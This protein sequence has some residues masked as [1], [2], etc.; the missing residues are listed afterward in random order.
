MNSKKRSRLDNSYPSS[1]SNVTVSHNNDT[2][3]EDQT[4]TTNTKKNIPTIEGISTTIA[5]LLIHCIKTQKKVFSYMATHDI[6]YS[7]YNSKYHNRIDSNSIKHYSTNDK[8]ITTTTNTIFDRIRQKQSD[9][10]YYGEGIFEKDN[11]QPFHTLSTC[12]QEALDQFLNQ[13]EKEVFSSS[14]V[15]YSHRRRSLIDSNVHSV[16]KA[17][18]SF[19]FDIITDTT[20]TDGGGEE[21]SSSSSSSTL[22]LPRSALHIL[23]NILLKYQ[24]SFHWLFTTSLEGYTFLKRF[25]H[26]IQSLTIRTMDSSASS[27]INHD[28]HHS[29]SKEKD[30]YHSLQYT[31]QIMTLFNTLSDIYPITSYPKL[32]VMKR[33]LKEQYRFQEPPLYNVE[34]SVTLTKNQNNISM[35]NLRHI[36]DIAL[37]I[38]DKVCIQIQRILQVMNNCFDILVPRYGQDTTSL[39]II[40]SKDTCTLNEIDSKDNHDD[41]NNNDDSDNL[42]TES[43][44]WEDGDDDDNF[45]VVD[46]EDHHHRRSM[47]SVDHTVAVNQSLNLMKARGTF[48]NGQM[49][50][51]M[52]MEDPTLSGMCAF[53]GHDRDSDMD[54]T[55]EKLQQCTQRLLTRYVPKVMSWIDALQNTDM[56]SHE[57]WDVDS[58]T[59]QKS[60]SLL[61]LPD[62]IQKKKDALL[63]SLISLKYDIQSVIRSARQLGVLNPNNVAV[64]DDTA[65]NTTKIGNEPPTISNDMTK[66]KS[67]I[68]YLKFN[69][70]VDDYTLSTNHTVQGIAKK[71]ADRISIKLF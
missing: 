11:L 36:R 28:H 17:C 38:G 27:S 42:D 23:G 39:I 40:S 55:Y 24:N 14:V 6:Q 49:K 34:C 51:N 1:M 61:L 33:L 15:A 25:L 71:S 63:K 69:D 56:L 30:K 67:N 9:T 62:N 59:V 5:P 16:I 20:N 21:G 58:G 10:F 37:S 68:P 54:P 66:L 2:K 52:D 47:N 12:A 32:L 35:T 53:K 46:D 29:S 19:L 4:K 60:E 8:E 3:K 13:L 48:D 43:I 57:I 44:H 50:V 18:I 26:S 45:F 31:Y 7:Y 70:T 64:T 41:N 22:V 65:L